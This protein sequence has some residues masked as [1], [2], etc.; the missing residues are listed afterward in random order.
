MCFKNKRLLAEN[1]QGKPLIQEFLGRLA[2]VSL[3]IW[4]SGRAGEDWQTGV[5]ISRFA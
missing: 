1:I 4:C 2:C 5:I 3:V